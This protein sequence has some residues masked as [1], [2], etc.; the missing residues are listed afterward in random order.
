MTQVPP[1]FDDTH[2]HTTV[3][4]TIDNLSNAFVWLHLFYRT[5]QDWMLNEKKKLIIHQYHVYITKQFRVTDEVMKKP[6][7]AIIYDQ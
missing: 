7:S 2:E 5:C 6:M 3:F 4:I 1:L